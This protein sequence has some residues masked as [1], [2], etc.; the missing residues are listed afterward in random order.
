M[1]KREFS[2]CGKKFRNASALHQHNRDMHPDRPV[3]VEKT[4][5]RRVFLPSFLGSLLGVLV[6]GGLLML[7]QPLVQSA[8]PVVKAVSAAVIRR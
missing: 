3:K 1:A 6:G 7:V 4:K 8:G 2:C 5:K